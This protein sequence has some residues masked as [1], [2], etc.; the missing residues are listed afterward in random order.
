[1]KKNE[2]VHCS[3]TNFKLNFDVVETFKT[4]FNI[5]QMSLQKKI[6]LILQFFQ[7]CACSEYYRYLTSTHTC[8]HIDLTGVCLETVLYRYISAECFRCMP[9][10]EAAV[11]VRRNSSI[12]ILLYE[13]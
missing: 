6:M 3:V 13:G 10:V 1:M 2:V 12:Y 8:M 5:F 4:K 7:A 11:H 9:L